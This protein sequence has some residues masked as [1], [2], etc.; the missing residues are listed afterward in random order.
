M[1]GTVYT[2][3][4]C[5]AQYPKWVGRCSECGQWGTVHAEAA[6]VPAHSKSKTPSVAPGATVDLTECAPSAPRRATGVSEVDRALDG[7]FVPGSTVLLGGEPGVG[8]S[9]LALQLA[10]RFAKNGQSTLYV[11][12]EESLDQVG[13]RLARLGGPLPALRFLGETDAAI[14]AA[15]IAHEHPAFVVVDSIQTLRDPEVKAA[16]G[17]PAQVRA[18]AGRVAAAARSSG[19]PALLVGQVVKS[20]AFAGPKAFEHAVDVVL[21][22]EGDPTHAFRLLTATKNRFG[23]TE[24]VGVFDLTASGFVPIPDPSRV[25][26]ANRTAAAGSIVAPVAGGSRVFL[27][28]IQAL[29]HPAGMGAPKRTT[30]GFEAPRLSVLLAVLERRAGIATAAHDVYINVAGGFRVVD[31]AADLAVCLAVASARLD[32]ALPA[33][34]TAVGEVGLGGEVRPV[35]RVAARLKEAKRLGLTRALVPKSERLAGASGAIRV[36]TVLEAL[37]A[38]GLRPQKS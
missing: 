21:M 6:P 15:T 11:A 32:V 16:A 38:A 37:S 20:G 35:S 19:C 5:D 17:T 33:D 34:L 2:C 23:G 1:S 28:E 31:P 14:V 10:R 36:A 9:T 18:S 13:L 12:G 27:V 30:S 3:A 22:L 29:T 8:K 25:L 7:G 24:E 26:L 4:N